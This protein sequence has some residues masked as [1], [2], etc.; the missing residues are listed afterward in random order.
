MAARITRMNMAVLR[1]LLVLMNDRTIA[2]V[3]AHVNLTLDI[4]LGV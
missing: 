1:S 4:T 2:P 3:P